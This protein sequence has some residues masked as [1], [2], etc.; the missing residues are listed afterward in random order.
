MKF[1]VA[2]SETLTQ[3]VVLRIVILC[4]SATT[5]ALL[6]A[7]VNL[8][9]KEPLLIER[10]CFTSVTQKA[11]GERTEAEIGSFLKEALSR[12]FDTNAMGET[13]VLSGEE[14][15]FRDQ[16]QKDLKEKGILQRVILNKVQKI[17]GTQVTVDCDRLVSVGPVRSAFAFPLHVTIGSVTRSEANPYGLRL[18]RV[19]AGESEKKSER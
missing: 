16:E 19:K 7:L 9:L 2:W 8:S 13:L 1:N 15:S 6:V 5:I 12:R 4:L 3:N 14:A 10:A 11:A 17:D 18:I